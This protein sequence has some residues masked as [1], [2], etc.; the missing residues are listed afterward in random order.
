ML[1]IV[2][3]EVKTLFNLSVHM[4]SVDGGNNVHTRLQ[5]HNCVVQPLLT[6]KNKPVYGFVISTCIH[7]VVYY[8]YARFYFSP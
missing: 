4:M 5:V 2:Q 7:T 8:L 1:L 6:G 3:V